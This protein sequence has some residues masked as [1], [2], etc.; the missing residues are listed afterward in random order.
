MSNKIIVPSQSSVSEMLSMLYGVE[1]DVDEVSSVNFS[2]VFIATFINDDGGTVAFCAADP[3]FVAY[4]GAAL[5]MMPAGGAEDMIES[6]EFSKT[7]ID[8]FYEVINVCSRLLMSDSSM[9][10]KLDKVLSP[11]EG[12]VVVNDFTAST[13]VGFSLKIPRY[14]VGKMAFCI[15]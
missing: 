6:G 13:T 15:S 10:L 2:G 12:E 1:V 7:S 5:S 4:S 14:G 8:N 11:A 3:S 9:H